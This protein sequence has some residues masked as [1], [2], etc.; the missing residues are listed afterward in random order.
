MTGLTQKKAKFIWFEACEKSFQE[1]KDKLTSDLV[2]TVPEGTDWF[3]VYSD[4][5]RIGLGYVLMQNSKIMPP[6]RAYTRD[7]NARN[8]NVIPLV[9]AH[10][11]LNVEFWN[12]IQLL[13]HNV[14]NKNSQHVPVPRFT[15]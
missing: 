11:V 10:E 5:S 12:V 13:A 15:S 8:A 6:H 2:L 4:A 1:L 14:V 9:P 7:A 3:G